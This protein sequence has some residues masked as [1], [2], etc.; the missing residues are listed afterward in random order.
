M[1]LSD[2]KMENF[3][4]AYEVVKFYLFYERWRRAEVEHS[5]H[6]LANLKSVC[7]CWINFSICSPSFYEHTHAYFGIF[8]ILVFWLC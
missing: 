2:T 7:V 6:Y 5:E 4:P 3:D 1:D 8:V